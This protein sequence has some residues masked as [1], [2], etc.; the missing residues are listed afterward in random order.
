MGVKKMKVFIM[1]FFA[2]VLSG[3]YLVAAQELTITSVKKQMTSLE[4]EIALRNTSDNDILVVMPNPK[5]ESKTKYYLVFDEKTHLLDI[6][7]NFYKYPPYITDIEPQCFTLKR[8]KSKEIYKERMFVK[9]P[10]SSSYLPIDIEINTNETKSIRFQI[11]ILP[12]DASLIELQNK[13]PFGHCVDG[14]EKILEGIY[15]DKTLIEVQNIL[16]T[17]EIK[18]PN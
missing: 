18:I 14:A 13:K 2:V 16:K 17:N 6:R 5:D 8:V 1:I 7:R 12:F 9:Y 10:V 4:I 11:G 3:N 15:K